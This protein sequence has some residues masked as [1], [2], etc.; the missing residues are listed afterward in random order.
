MRI[1]IV[2]CYFADVAVVGVNVGGYGGVLDRVVSMSNLSNI[3]FE[4]VET[5]F[6]I[7]V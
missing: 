1:G 4:V 3:L 2:S 6:L 7:K 5:I